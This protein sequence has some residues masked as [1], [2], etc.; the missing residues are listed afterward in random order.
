MQTYTEL[1]LQYQNP[2]EDKTTITKFH[3]GQTITLSSTETNTSVTGKIVNIYRDEEEE[4]DFNNPQCYHFTVEDLVGK[5]HT[6][7]YNMF[8]ADEVDPQW[9]YN[10]NYYDDNDNSIQ[11]TS[12]IYQ[13]MEEMKGSMEQMQD[14]VERLKAIF[15]NISKNDDV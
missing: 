2:N 7:S 12:N 4:Q 10:E 11:V 13:V 8:P 1:T 14:S 6:I 15:Q 3:I 5:L 9:F